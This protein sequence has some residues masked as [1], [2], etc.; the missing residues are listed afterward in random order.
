MGRQPFFKHLLSGAIQALIFQTFKSFFIALLDTHEVMSLRSLYRLLVAL[1][2][3]VSLVLIMLGS[4]S[5]M[6]RKSVQAFEASP[7]VSTLSYTMGTQTAKGPDWNHIQFR[8]LPAIQEP[9]WIKMPANS[10][11]QLGYDPSRTW[12]AGQTP[13]QFVML[14]DVQDAFHLEK[15]NLQQISQLSQNAID[16]LNLNDFGMSQ[17]QTPKS[18][19]EA[20]PAIAELPLNQIKPLQDLWTKQGSGALGTNTLAQIV[21]HVPTF[22]ATPLGKNLDLTRYSLNSIPNLTSTSLSQFKGWQRSFVEQVPGLNQVPFSQFPQAPASGVG[23]AA[24]ADVVWSAAEHGDPKVT[25]N[26]FVTGSALK[27]GATAPVACEAGKPCSYVELSD[28]TG[29]TGAMH[30]KRWASGATQRVK[31]GYGFLAKVNGGWEPTGRLVYGSAFKVVM[32]KANEAKGQADFGLYLRACMHGIVDL[33]CTPYFIGPVPWIPVQE[34]GLVIIAGKNAPAVKIPSEFQNQVSTIEGQYNAIA[35]PGGAFDDCGG[36]TVSGEAVNRAIAAAPSSDRPYAQKVI[37]LVLADAKRYGVTDPAQVAYILATAQA[38][39]NFNPRDEDDDYSRS[40]ACGNYCGRGLVQLTHLE[41]YDRAGKAIGVDLVNQPQLA[42]RPDIAS[43]VMVIGMR[44]GWFTGVGLGSYIRGG[45]TNFSGARQIV[46]DGD[47]AGE[48]AQYAQRYYEAIRGTN[49]SA[50]AEKPGQSC[51]PK[52]KGATAQKIAQA[53]SR[54]VGESTAAGPGGGNVACAWEVNRVL[55]KAGIPSI[56]GDSVPNM[57]AVLESGRGQRVNPAQAGPGDIV[58]AH[59]MQHVGICMNQGCN[60]V[61]S[62]SSSR[63]Q[64]SWQSDRNFDGFYGGAS[65]GIYRVK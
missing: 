31:G 19:V 55:A 16:T 40:G 54:S 15:F 30:G 58:I 59:D 25:A 6:S 27:T 24:I 52:A 51:A 60:R 47:R 17:W 46:N 64:F 42:N 9:G 34:K 44:E 20:I 3:I 11:K 61:M 65:E 62:N 35:N 48:I 57:V 33:G 38:E 29:Q 39:V 37:P 2:F 18:L 28:L 43:K 10:V 53:A 4:V 1:L 41:N 63:K 36:G 56:D 14:G 26:S 22:A 50:L 8:T 12:S 21:E 32:T 45:S 23:I 13:D 7:S 49:I 5:W